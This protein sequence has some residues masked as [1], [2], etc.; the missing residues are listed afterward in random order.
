MPEFT[1]RLMRA[2]DLP[3][4]LDVQAQCYGDA[5]IESADALSSRL[6]LSPGTC[7][8]A[9]LSDGTLAGYL[10]THAWPEATLP[11]WNG[12]LVCDWPNDE[13]LTWF[14]HDMAVAPIGRGLRL[15]VQLH[16][17]AR[18]VAAASGLRSSRLVAVQSADRYWRRFGY[19][20]MAAGKHAA[21]LEM[22]GA[23]AVLMGCQLEIKVPGSSS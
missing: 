7:W 5:L 23:G 4:I 20:P 2:A 13:P 19:A 12:Q 11:P 15:A 9:V 16:S 8:V 10:F 22:Y 1:L 6:A 14:V 18:D 17:A 21:K 3:A